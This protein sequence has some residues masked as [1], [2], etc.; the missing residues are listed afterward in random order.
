MFIAIMQNSW[1]RGASKDEATKIAAK[2]GGHGRKRA[3][4]L[5]FEYDAAK[6]PEVFVDEM[7][8]LCWS[9][10]KPTEV[11]RVGMPKP[12]EKPARVSP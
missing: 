3:P 8:R 9:G 11:E 12:G 7:G 10:D 5:V 1:G 6:T 4:R 2:E